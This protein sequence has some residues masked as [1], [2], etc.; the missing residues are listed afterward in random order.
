M[1]HCPGLF[2]SLSDRLAVFGRPLSR[3]PR[4]GHEDNSFRALIQSLYTRACLVKLSFLGVVDE[5]Q[6]HMLLS[7]H[8]DS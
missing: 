4:L 2:P 1:V 5:I 7:H 8:T 6:M 3:L